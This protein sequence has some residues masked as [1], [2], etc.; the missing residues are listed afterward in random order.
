MVI[1]N[2]TIPLFA[3]KSF[4]PSDFPSSGLFVEAVVGCRLLQ[5]SRCTEACQIALQRHCT[6]YP[7]HATKNCFGFEHN[8]HVP[9]TQLLQRLCIDRQLLWPPQQCPKE[10]KTLI[11]SSNYIL[12]KSGSVGY[13]TCSRPGRSQGRSWVRLGG[14]H[15]RDHTSFVLANPASCKWSTYFSFSQR[16]PLKPV[17]LQKLEVGSPMWPSPSRHTKGPRQ[18]CTRTHVQEL[19]ASLRLQQKGHCSSA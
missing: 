17:S 16:W 13:V 19:L 8:S 15:A 12:R 3:G 6:N 11:G 9:S 2:T 7:T 10:E 14:P 1:E 18:A 5:G 4:Y